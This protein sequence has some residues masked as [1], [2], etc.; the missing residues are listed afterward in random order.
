MRKVIILSVMVFAVFSLMATDS[1]I[2]S[3]RAF[4]NGSNITIEWASNDE[5]SIQSYTLQR[6][7]NNST[8]KTVK[9]FQANGKSSEYKYID[10]EAFMKGGETSTQTE[11]MYSY[12]IKITHLDG[13]TQYTDAISVINQTNSIRRTWGMIK[14]MFR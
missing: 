1:V 5:T 12:R 3:F 4:A 11:K 8:F 14:E 10:E 9:F 6:N 13:N 7:T 2:S